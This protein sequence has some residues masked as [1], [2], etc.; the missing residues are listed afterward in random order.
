[1]ALWL[2]AIAA[3]AEN[4][5]HLHLVP[6]PTSP[7]DSQLL[8]T[9][10]PRCPYSKSKDILLQ[11]LWTTELLCIYPHTDRCEYTQLKCKIN[12]KNTVV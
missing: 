4:A 12:L 11:L 3:L 1:M 5:P 6:V 10:A 2:G 7:G 9:P 8:E